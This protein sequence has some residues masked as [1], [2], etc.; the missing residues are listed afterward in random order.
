MTKDKLLERATLLM[1][2]HEKAKTHMDMITGHLN[3][4]KYQLS[5]WIDAP[6]EGD[7]VPAEPVVEPVSEI[8]DGN[9]DE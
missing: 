6:M 9:P 8:V 4:V 5:T 7:L 3:E 2:E 1:T